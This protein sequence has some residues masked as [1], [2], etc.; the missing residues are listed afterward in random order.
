MWPRGQVYNVNSMWPSTLP[1]GT[2]E[3]RLILSDLAPLVLGSPITTHCVQFVKYDLIQLG[4][5]PVTPNSFSNLCSRMVLST[6][7]KA[8]DK[9]YKTRHITF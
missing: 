6:V 3:D 1:W 4:T 5:I 2:P 8:A 9:S 7:S